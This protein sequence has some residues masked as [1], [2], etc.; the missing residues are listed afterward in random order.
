M[1]DSDL[2]DKWP[3]YA[4]RLKKEF[5]QLTTDDL[6][7]EAGKEKETLQ[8][9]QDKLKKTKKEIRDWLCFLG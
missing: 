9:L 3:T 6:I 4:Q 8:R 7:L 1:T 2:A 5:P